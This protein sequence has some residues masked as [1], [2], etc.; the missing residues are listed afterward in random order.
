MHD[1]E[2]HGESEDQE[3]MELGELDLQ[4]IATAW[5][6][7]DPNSIPNQQ[8]QLLKDALIRSKGHPRSSHKGKSVVSS[9]LGVKTNTLK[10][11]SK[12]SKVEKR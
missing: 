7:Q 10:N 4:S 6:W 3:N 8:L 5:E 2:D 1:G 12:I 11:N 9:S